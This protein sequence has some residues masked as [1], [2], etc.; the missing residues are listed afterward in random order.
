MRFAKPPDGF[1]V[2]C[3]SE[4]Q[5]DITNI[6]GGDLT[7]LAYKEGVVERLRQSGHRLGYEFNWPEVPGTR[8]YKVKWI[9][10]GRALEVRVIYRVLG[11]TIT[12][13]RVNVAREFRF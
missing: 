10:E 3:L 12:F 4:A 7:C 1:R 13:Y 5:E 11:D 2:K 6:C 8:L 9:G